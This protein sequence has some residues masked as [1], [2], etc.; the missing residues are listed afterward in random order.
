MKRETGACVGGGSRADRMRKGGDSMDWR[1]RKEE[2]ERTLKE[3][4]ERRKG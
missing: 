3:R 4:H 2:H 1:M